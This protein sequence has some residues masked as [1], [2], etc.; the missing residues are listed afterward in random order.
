[1]SRLASGSRPGGPEDRFWNRQL[2]AFMARTRRPSSSQYDQISSRKQGLVSFSARMPKQIWAASSR[3]S[4]VDDG[5]VR[6]LSRIS[7]R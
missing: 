4:A 2:M 3:S 1:M 5:D 6:S 7:P